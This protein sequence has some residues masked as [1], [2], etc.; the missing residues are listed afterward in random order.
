MNLTMLPAVPRFRRSLWVGIILLVLGCVFADIATFLTTWPRNALV[1]L[2]ALPLI[3]SGLIVFAISV[4]KDRKAW[5]RLVRQVHSLTLIV[6]CVVAGALIWLNLAPRVDTL[7]RFRK[8][9]SIITS[10]TRGWPFPLYIKVDTTVFQPEHG[11]G[12]RESEYPRRQNKFTREGFV[13]TWVYWF[14]NFLH[15]FLILLVILFVCEGSYGEPHL[16]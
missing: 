12:P 13:E 11:L 4:F 7:K 2:P 16:T 15:W 10:T 14:M 1:G 9:D 6:L 3:V 5:Q 8:D